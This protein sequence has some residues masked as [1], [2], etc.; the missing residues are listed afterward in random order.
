VVAD[1]HQL[2]EEEDPDPYWGEKLDPDPHWS[3]KLD[4]DPHWSEKLDPDPI[5]VMRIRNPGSLKTDS[6]AFYYNT[7]YVEGVVENFRRHFVY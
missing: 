1:S 3:E 5:K 4:P 2:D 6:A 7:V